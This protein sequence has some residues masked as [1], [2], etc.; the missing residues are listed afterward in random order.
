MEEVKFPWKFRTFLPYLMASI[1]AVLLLA[2]YM[3]GMTILIWI[4]FIPILVG[5]ILDHLYQKELD[6]KAREIIRYKP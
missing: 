6:R 5:L 1:A 4:V 3:T 2:A